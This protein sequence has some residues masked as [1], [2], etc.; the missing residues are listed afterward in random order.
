MQSELIKVGYSLNIN[1][2]L[3]KLDIDFVDQL[4]V[5]ETVESDY[6]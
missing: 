1:K 5:A 3:A 2:L 6:L 4:P